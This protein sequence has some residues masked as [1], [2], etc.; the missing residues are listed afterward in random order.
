VARAAEDEGMSETNGRIMSRDE[1]LDYYA[2]LF[3]FLEVG[4]VGMILE[5]DKHEWKRELIRAHLASLVEKCCH[6]R[7]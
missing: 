1:N 4:F 3:L 7:D 5:R 6:D 2:D